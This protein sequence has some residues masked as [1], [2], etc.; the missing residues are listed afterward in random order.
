[1]NISWEPSDPNVSLE[2]MLRRT[3]RVAEQIFEKQ[4]GIDLLWWFDA[5]SNG[6]A[7]ITA[8]LGTYDD[9]KQDLYETLR[10]Q[11]AVWGVTRF[12]VV[13]EA[14]GTDNKEFVNC[15]SEDPRRREAV[16]HIAKD[17]RETLC[18]MREIHRPPQGKP[19][20]AKLEI[21]RDDHARGGL[22]MACCRQCNEPRRGRIPR[23]TKETE[24]D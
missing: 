10:K 12:V 15:P 23:N 3:S 24:H 2:A 4:G 18:A 6:S 16:L 8:R 22:T 19:Y 9:A 13:C 17:A 5:P 1:M 20:L 11:F 7:M 21:K 14:Y